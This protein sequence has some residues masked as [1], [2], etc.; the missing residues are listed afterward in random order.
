M[1][2]KIL[3]YHQKIYT[4]MMVASGLRLEFIPPKATNARNIHSY[5]KLWDW[6]PDHNVICLNSNT[7]IIRIVDSTLLHVLPSIFEVDRNALG[8]SLEVDTR[9]GS[10]CFLHTPFQ[11]RSTI[12]QAL[13]IGQNGQE[14]KN[15]RVSNV[16]TRGQSQNAPIS[17]SVVYFLRLFSKIPLKAAKTSIFIG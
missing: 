17:S 2:F 8:G 13:I 4:C 11:E 10:I 9:L 3:N 16:Q 6:I 15:W 7:P 1:L 5:T 12:P 14:I